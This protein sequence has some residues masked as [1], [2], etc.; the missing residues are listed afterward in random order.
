VMGCVGM[1]RWL[2]AR[3]AALHP[4]CGYRKDG[5]RAAARARRLTTTQ[6]IC[7]LTC[8]MFLPA[9]LPCPQPP[10]R[11]TLCWSLAWLRS[12][13]RCPS[14]RRARRAGRTRRRRRPR[15]LRWVGA[16]KERSCGMCVFLSCW[17]FYTR[18]ERLVIAVLVP[19]W[20]WTRCSRSFRP[21]LTH[22]H[23]HARSHPR[24]HFERR[25]STNS[26]ARC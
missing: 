16:Q 11:C 12:R 10:A 3:A 6:L 4:A 25:S 19:G 2:G 9:C 26:R 18:G 20:C 5:Q 13:G 22:F 17:A 14:P 8:S 24:P 15:A 7:F 21:L 23:S 1:G